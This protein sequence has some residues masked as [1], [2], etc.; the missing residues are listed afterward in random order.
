M[1][2]TV[3]DTT[4]LINFISSFRLRYGTPLT[5]I[6]VRPEVHEMLKE[7]YRKFTGGDIDIPDVIKVFYGVRVYVDPNQ[8]Q[9]MKIGKPDEA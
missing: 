3:V 5:G 1:A 2:G 7:K 4:D 8:V 6:T 9:P